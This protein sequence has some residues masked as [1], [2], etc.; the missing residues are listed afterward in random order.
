MK[1]NVQ[2]NDNYCIKAF[3]LI[4]GFGCSTKL[5]KTKRLHVFSIDEIFRFTINKNLGYKK[6]H[7]PSGLD[8]RICKRRGILFQIS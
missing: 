5:D 7:L 1:S 3:L 6:P 2:E 8:A 4:Y